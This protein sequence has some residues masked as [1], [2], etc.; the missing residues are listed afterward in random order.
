[1]R[2]DLDQLMDEL[3]ERETTLRARDEAWFVLSH[4]EAAAR[5]GPGAAD[6]KRQ[7]CRARDPGP[8]DEAFRQAALETL[9]QPHFALLAGE[10]AV[11]LPREDSAALGAVHPRS[12]SR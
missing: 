2:M 4:Q 10:L 1:M 8:L 7:R 11:R 3:P 12:P 5:A 6:A 9:G